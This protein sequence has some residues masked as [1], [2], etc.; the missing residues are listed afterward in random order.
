[1]RVKSK[2]LRIF[3]IIAICAVILIGA[4]FAVGFGVR[5]TIKG[6]VEVLL[7]DS[8]DNP[9][10]HQEIHV[11]GIND[12]EVADLFITDDEGKITIKNLGLRELVFYIPMITNAFNPYLYQAQHKVTLQEIRQGAITVKF[13]YYFLH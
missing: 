8:N 6:D 9:I 2:K 10:I 5:K 3:L 7:I 4:G 1:M 13:E 12:Y 11:G